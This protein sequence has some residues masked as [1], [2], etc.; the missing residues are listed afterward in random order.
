MLKESFNS[1]Y[2]AELAPVLGRLERERQQM[3]RKLIF[4][5]IVVAAS[6]AALFVASP[7]FANPW[8]SGAI[9]LV[10]VV[11]AMSNANFSFGKSGAV[12]QNF[13]S[14]PL[15]QRLAL[16][17]LVGGVVFVLL[18]VGGSD[19]VFLLVLGFGAAAAVY[20]GITSG[21]RLKFK[22]QVVG[23]LVDF[24]DPSL[25]YHPQQGVGRSVYTASRLFLRS[26]DRYSEEDLVAGQVGQTPIRFS[27][28]HSE[29]K[30]T[31]TDSKGRRTEH[32]HTI[33]RGVLFVADFPKNFKGLTVV[34]PE[35]FMAGVFGDSRGEAVKLEDPE[36]ERAFRV[37]S[38][39]QVE[40]RF[41]LST[42]LM[43]RI[44]DFKERSRS[45]IHLSF[46]GGN[47]Y[48]AISLN[49]NLF[50]P[51]ILRATKVSD[52]MTYLA[53]LRFA[54]GVVEDLN[55]NQRIWGS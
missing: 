53:D 18:F 41:L 4:A 55:L 12:P 38:N 40:A 28:V 17:L 21:Y 26:A 22:Q 32:W 39:D 54:I 3:V 52:L 36:F 5:E 10:L 31:S 48:I 29:Y 34:L 45:Q 23:R 19:P 14:A 35:G 49:R 15:W 50:E 51:S 9:A 1:F 24:V 20:Q 42:S 46:S 11:L 8:I 7:L 30:T 27:E 13:K 33:F 25:D 43:E 2:Q 44:L 16:A 47:L 6:T 37:Y